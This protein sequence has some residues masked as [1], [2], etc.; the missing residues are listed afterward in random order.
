M[1]IY[2]A[3]N[4]VTVQSCPLGYWLLRCIRLYLE[5]DMYAA[6]EVHT[7]DTIS[8]GRHTVKA[9]SALMKVRSWHPVPNL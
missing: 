6:L 5:V 3:H 4:I 7:S 8:E 9:F 1:I 2:A